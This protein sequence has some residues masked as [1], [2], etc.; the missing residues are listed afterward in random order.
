MNAR[1]TLESARQGALRTLPVAFSVFAYGMVYGL[2]TRQAG[3]TLGE[4]AL[5]S[6]LIFAGSS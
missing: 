5:S 6:G 2:L 3:L 1:L 4:A